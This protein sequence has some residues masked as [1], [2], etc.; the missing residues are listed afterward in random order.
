MPERSIQCGTDFRRGCTD[1]LRAGGARGPTDKLMDRP[2]GPS[3][4]E[5]TEAMV[6]N[7]E[8]ELLE[9]RQALARCR[10]DRQA[11]A[12]LTGAWMAHLLISGAALLKNLLIDTAQ[13]PRRIEQGDPSSRAD[14][15]SK[16]PQARPG[17]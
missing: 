13:R 17:G 5:S 1:G 14:G 2:A 3:P 11:E 8:R 16:N 7:I 15:S 10:V 9:I 4:R 6:R 12:Q